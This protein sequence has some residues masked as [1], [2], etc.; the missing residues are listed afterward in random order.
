MSK[1]FTRVFIFL[2]AITLW[3][4]GLFKPA[5]PKF[6][7]IVATAE[8]THNNNGNRGRGD[9]DDRG[10]VRGDRGDRGDRGNRGRGRGNRGDRDV[11][12]DRGDRGDRGRGRGNRG[13]RRNPRRCQPPTVS[14]LPI[15]YMV[16][17]GAATIALSGGLVFY[18]RQRK[19]E[20]SLE[21]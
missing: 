11:R 13:C 12:G 18:I 9:R 3:Q 2:F 1:F 4:L 7:G 5:A 15:Q 19:T 20:R 8:A 14:E 17:S 10:D 21:A 16:M 6:D